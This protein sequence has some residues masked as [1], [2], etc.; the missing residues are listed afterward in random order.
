MLIEEAKRLFKSAFAAGRLSHAYIVVGPPRGAAAGFATFAMQM[1]VCEG[2]E[3]PCGICE[4]CKKIAEQKFP[5]VMW[6]R[7]MK[8]SRVISVDQMRR[9]PPDTK[10]DIPPPYFLT[11]LSETSMLGGWK[12]GV[13]EYADRMNTSA[14][15]ALLKTLEE[16]P[17]DTMLLLLTD[18]PQMLLPTIISRCGM[19]TLSSPPQELDEKYRVPLLELLSTIRE[20]GA[21]A[22]Y[23]YSQKILAMLAEMQKEAEQEAKAEAAKSEESGIDVES[24]EKKE[25]ESA[26]Y[27]QK[28]SLLVETIQR[29]LR[30]LLAVVAAGKEAPVHYAEYR[31]ALATQASKVTLSAALAN[32]E[33]VESLYTQLE[34]RNMAD[35]AIFP[36]WLDRIDFGVR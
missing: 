11:W 19:V 28:R 17:A 33:A 6:L 9:G 36:Y 23:A 18:K 25:R 20:G 13:V 34:A 7:P 2:L 26:L 21:F 24:D 16:P 1:L 15:N 30:D 5:D 4:A 12:F 32:I 14:Q 8:K 31:E 22:A 27:R 3:K 29:W 10:N 35:S